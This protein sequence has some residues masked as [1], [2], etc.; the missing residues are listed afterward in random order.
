M[1]VNCGAGAFT[2]G[3]SGE[4]ALFAIGNDWQGIVKNILGIALGHIGAT[5]ALRCAEFIVPIGSV[6]RVVEI[7]EHCPGNV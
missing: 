4:N 6:D 5:C 2:A 3:I 1:V 7:I